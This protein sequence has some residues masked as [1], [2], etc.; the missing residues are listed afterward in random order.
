MKQ[1]L[2]FNNRLFALAFVAIF[3]IAIFPSAIHAENNISLGYSPFGFTNLKWYPS[4]EHNVF[5]KV[6]YNKSW[7]ANITYEYMKKGIGFMTEFTYGQAKLDKLD[8]VRWADDEHYEPGVSLFKEKD[9]DKGLKQFGGAMYLGLNF[10]TGHRFQIPLYVGGAYDRYLSEP[11]KIGFLSVA[12]KAR[13]R[14]Y[15]VNE[16]SIYLGA[17]YKYGVSLDKKAESFIYEFNYYL[18][19]DDSVDHR[20]TQRQE[21]A[22]DA[23]LIFSF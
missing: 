12:A 10:F 22:A 8:I 1:K 3:L 6:D 2:I 20:K 9:F 5:Y 23:G 14:L 19:G 21:F 15:I 17:T 16:L 7:N 18:P 11:Y 13:L 4:E